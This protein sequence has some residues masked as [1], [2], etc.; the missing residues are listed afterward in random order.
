MIRILSKTF[1]VILTLSVIALL[2]WHL[3]PRSSHFVRASL[4]GASFSEP[5]SA[6]VDIT[7]SQVVVSG[8][9]HP[10]QVTHAGDG[11]RRLFVVEQRGTIRIIEDD[12]LQPTP[13][14][15]ITDRVL[16]GG[17]RGLL[18]VAFPPD[19]ETSQR[20][21]VN[22][23]RQPDGATIVARFSAND[24]TADPGSEQILLTIP[25][26]YAN[27][28]GGLMLFGPNDGH[29][30]IGTGDGGSGGDPLDN[31]QDPYSL[32]GKIL[33][34]DVSTA[35]DPYTIP[36]DNPYAT[37]GGQPEIWSLGLRNPWRFSFDR[38]T[39]DMYIGDV[40]QNLWEEID[41]E[42]AYTAGGVNYGWRCK[43]GSH[44]YNFTGDCVNLTFSDP[45]AEYNHSEGNS[46]TG[47]YVYRGALYP[48]LIGRYFY[49]DYVNGKIW[50]LY[51]TGTNPVTWSAPELEL[52]T[53][54]PISAFG[55]DEDGELYV[56]NYG[57]AVHRLADANGPSPN[58][59]N[60]SKQASTPYA[61]TG[62]V[63]TYTIRLENSGAASTETVWLTDTLPA[64]LSYVPGSATATAGSLT[65]G[66][67][68]ILWEG[69]LDQA[70]ITITYKASVEATE[71]GSLINRVAIDGPSISPISLVTS[72][73]IPR[74]ALN[75]SMEDTF[76][77][78]TQPGSLSAAVDIAAGCDF[79]HSPPIYDRWR[80]SAMSQAGRDPLMWA[81]LA[82]SNSV[83]PASG[84]FCLRCHTGQG[85]LEGRSHPADGSA[86]V[87]TDIND[88]VGC[89]LCH[90]LVDPIPS[91]TDE[92]K[93][94]D[95]V[96]RAALTATIPIT[97][98][99]SGMLIVDPQDNRR[100][101]FTIAPPPPHTAYKTDLF[102][103]DGDIVTQARLCG[104][105]H[106]L[107]NPYMSW[108]EGRNQ[109]WPNDS[110]A[111]AP[112]FNKDNM[113]PV[114]RT[115]DEW[116]LS[117]FAKPAGVYAPE[118][119]GALS[120]GIVHTCQDCHMQR[121]TGAAAEGIYGGTT[122]DCET[123]GCLPQ[124]GFV[125]GNTWLPTLLQDEDWRL[126]SPTSQH[127]HLD[128]SQDDSRSMLRKAASISV[129]MTLS[130]TDQVAFVRVT[131][132]TGHK[133]PT[134]Y[135]EGRR[136]W[137]NL[138]A[139]ASDGSVVFES[140][141]Y[142]EDTGILTEDA[143]AKIY[144]IKPGITEELAQLL[145]MPDVSSG[146]SF[147]F[148]LNNTVYKDNRIPPRGYTQANF[149]KPGLQ[150]VGATYLDG[151]YWDD[152]LYLLPSTTVQVEVRLYYQL[153]SKEYVD[154]LR[155][156]GGI[157]GESLGEMWDEQ[158]SEPQI[159]DR[160]CYPLE[161]D[162]ILLPLILKESMAT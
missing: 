122:R 159:I 95:A 67:S 99:S 24:S 89:A 39:G 34:I 73:F 12:S 5:I 64:G 91:T 58:L 148:L 53:G 62:E 108:D 70:L 96:V 114:E 51:Q 7:V 111:P 79:C 16:Y 66:A 11:S 86:L 10:V 133:L 38:Q 54:F 85:W 72:V 74:P 83:L 120:D 94:I 19:F 27:H 104:S 49:A 126:Q 15:N 110:G 81:A 17:E 43:E 65:P 97:N 142:D 69:A 140:A 75:T 129:T 41:Y 100:G 157:D 25:Q 139:Y 143:Q 132:N 92:A 155:A 37:S 137:I 35:V 6:D 113:L 112:S 160:D 158:K 136:T 119:A 82:A 105:C 138:R 14:L 116:L 46:V 47:G 135:P 20:F 131:N 31:A 150:P 22:Y 50:S 28:N 88:G 127:A 56:V 134:G 76:L 93:A 45:I 80:G 98:I 115:F 107:D 106:N 18:S 3:L 151:Q 68:A 78:G 128:V 55:E 90:R 109:Y 57:G 84:D 144:E 2:S 36:A 130:G 32:L 149:D 123:N 30:Y 42:P 102:A 71:T 103:Q 21:Y 153:S 26:P 60:S 77:P 87:E 63:V 1:L 156:R 161:C 52:S 117:D 152:T 121:V 8:L 44:D 59:T 125:G 13:F 61:D 162:A 141:A 4:T 29:L 154:F 40:G 23:T 118:F 146:P 48:A 33:R 145:D 124:H 9:D 147:Y 101:P